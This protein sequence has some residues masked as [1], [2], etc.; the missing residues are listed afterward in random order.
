MTL[1]EYLLVLRN[2]L[3]PAGLALGLLCAG[4]FTWSATPRYTASTTL[5]ISAQ[6]LHNDATSVY[7][8]NQLAMERVKTYTALIISDRIRTEV[9]DRLRTEIAP[10]Q[11]SATSQ[12]E[13]VLITATVTDTSPQQ[14]QQIAD[15]VGVEFMALLAQ[16]EKPANDT[17]AAPTV[18]ARVVQP[19]ELPTHPISPH[20]AWNLAVGAGLGLLLGYALALLR[21]VL[22]ASPKSADPSRIAPA[23]SQPNTSYG[24][25]PHP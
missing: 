17:E 25:L 22:N 10:G 3:L 19:A 11:I 15:A 6:G 20:P 2:W 21:S 24:S 4:A 12:P 7:Q 16:F 13:T 1:R 23:T 9:S 18:I 14:A 5:F 8:G